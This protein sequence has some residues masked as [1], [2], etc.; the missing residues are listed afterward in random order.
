MIL[1]NPSFYS[2]IEFR[3]YLSLSGMPYDF[4]LG[5]FFHHDIK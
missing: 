5:S 2:S 1:L 3:T 4:S